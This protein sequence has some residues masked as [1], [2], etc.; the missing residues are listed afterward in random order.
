[1]LLCPVFESI[2]NRI[3]E[4]GYPCEVDKTLRKIHSRSIT[5]PP[6]KEFVLEI[7]FKATSLKHGAGI[8]DQYLMYKGD[9]RDASV[10]CEVKTTDAKVPEKSNPHPI[11]FYTTGKIQEEL[12][13]F[14]KHVFPAG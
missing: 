9:D 8:F 13:K 2:K 1:M 3:V 6:D 5:P 14:L 10:V 4:A 7:K 11:A 12:E